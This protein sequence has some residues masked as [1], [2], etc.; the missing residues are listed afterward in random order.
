MSIAVVAIALLYLIEPAMSQCVKTTHAFVVAENSATPLSAAVT[1]SGSSVISKAIDCSDRSNLTLVID[2]ENKSCQFQLNNSVGLL[3][4][5]DAMGV[6]R[7]NV[8]LQ[9]VMWFAG[10]TF[11]SKSFRSGGSLRTNSS[12]ILANVSQIDQDGTW[13]AFTFIA[14]NEAASALFRPATRFVLALPT[15]VLVRSLVL[16]V[17]TDAELMPSGNF[18]SACSAGLVCASVVGGGERRARHWPRLVGT[19]C[20]VRQCVLWRCVCLVEATQSG[21]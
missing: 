17:P 18:T 20:V 16:R 14:E 5:C 8:T 10:V 21:H 2:S 7:V 12:V 15:A 6:V 13:N 4:Q 19:V 9:R 1:A 11:D 3:V